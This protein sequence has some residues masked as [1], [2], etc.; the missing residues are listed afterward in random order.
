M[1]FR[2]H[3]LSFIKKDQKS[4][5]GWPQQPPTEKVP[6]ISEKL[7]FWSSIP[8]KGTS[9]GHFSARDDQTIRARKFFWENLAL[10]A[11]EASEVAEAV[12]A[13]E[14]A[15]AVEFNEAGEVSRAWKITMKDFWVIQVLEFNNLRTSNILYFDVSKKIKSIFSVGGCW[16]QP[17]LLFWFFFDKSQMVDSWE[18]ANHHE[19]L[20]M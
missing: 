11:V 8:Q 10:E 15:E 3:H 18:H 20:L 17:M 14:V 12:E 5:I 16:G 6:N 9:I 4:N 7:D 19:C 13:S 2:V 1:F